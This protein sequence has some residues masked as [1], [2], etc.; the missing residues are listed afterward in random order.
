M[1]NKNLLVLFFVTVGFSISEQTTPE[2]E[3]VRANLRNDFNPKHI[4]CSEKFRDLAYVTARDFHPVVQSLTEYWDHSKFDILNLF[5]PLPCGNCKEPA[6]K[7]ENDVNF[8]IAAFREE[9]TIDRIYLRARDPFREGYQRFLDPAL[10]YI[11]DFNPNQEQ[12]KEALSCWTKTKSS[13]LTIFDGTYEIARQNLTSSIQ[14]FKLEYQQIGEN[15][16]A[17]VLEAIS[18][19]SKCAKQGFGYCE[20]VYV[21]Y[22][23]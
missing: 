18:E 23:N 12:V 5:N 14:T 2:Q 8:N 9:L 22:M 1:N 20:Y 16:T 4:Q 6:R 21:S 19:A 15:F 17:G 10:K 11:E 7:I 13:I 3:V